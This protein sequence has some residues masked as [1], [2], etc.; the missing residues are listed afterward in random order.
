MLHS[1]PPPTI[2]MENSG[3]IHILLASAEAMALYRDS[4]NALMASESCEFMVHRFKKG[5]PQDTIDK[6]ME[7]W[8]VSMSIDR[9]Q[10]R[11]LHHN[12]CSKI[13]ERY[14]RV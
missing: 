13:R 5:T 7:G 10:Y 3:Y 9:E 11:L 6:A 2:D 4:I 14:S 12:L 8:Q 1:Q